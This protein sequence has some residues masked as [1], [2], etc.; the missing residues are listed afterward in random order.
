MGMGGPLEIL[1]NGQKWHAPIS[2]T[3]VLGSIEDWII[4]NPT[5]DTHP[6]H[7]HLTQFQLVSRQKLDTVKYYAD[8]VALNGEPPFHHE[9]PQELAVAQYLKGKPKMAEPQEMGWKDTVQMNPGEMTII[10]VKFAPIDGSA[11]YPF[12]A[13]IGPGYVWH[14]HILDHEDNEMMRPYIVVAATARET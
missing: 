3:P 11:S 7:L 4:V 10:R 14:C 5:M 1:L 2:E 8:W 12:D 13:T 6:I 9:T